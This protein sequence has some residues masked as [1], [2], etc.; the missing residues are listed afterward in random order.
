MLSQILKI[1]ADATGAQRV[2]AGLAGVTNKAFSA[3]GK[4]IS[5]R[6]VGAFAAGAVLDRI[7]GFIKDT[8]D[9][10]DNLGDL[11]ENL[12]ITIE[13][14][15]R[16]EVASGRAGVRFS[17]MQVILDKITALQAQALDGDKKAVGIFA[18]LGLDP[19]QAN[20][21]QIM[22]AAIANQSVAADLFGKRINNVANVIA[23]LKT[24]GPIE[25]ITKEQADR[26]GK[27]NDDIAEVFRQTKTAATP[28][29]TGGLKLSTMILNDLNSLFGNLS[30]VFRPPFLQEQSIQPIINDRIGK[31]AGSGNDTQPPPTPSPISLAAQSDALGRIGLFIGGRGDAGNQLVTIGNYQLTELRRVRSILE[32]ANR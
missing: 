6:I 20:A 11:A 13:E 26:L 25:V 23:Q 19:A 22:E 16:L 3:V 18:A 15:Q 32:E 14:V 10:A 7:G 24:L 2:I 9:Y 5:G 28:A 29:I 12:G 4:E 27:A 30:N 8:V 1:G 17:K 31:R 21:L